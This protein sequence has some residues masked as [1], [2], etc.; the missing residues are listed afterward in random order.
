MKF[1]VKIIKQHHE[2]KGSNKEEKGSVSTLLGGVGIGYRD[3]I[4][5]QV[6]KSYDSTLDI[7]PCWLGWR[8]GWN[9]SFRLSQSF[10]C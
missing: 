9:K 6:S 7:Y 10:M 5:N 3:Y 8:R 1:E 4:D 2:D